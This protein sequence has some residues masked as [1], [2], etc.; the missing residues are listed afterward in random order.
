MRRF[1]IFILIS[2]LSIGT[3]IAQDAPVPLRVEYFG[4]MVN[5]PESCKLSAS[6][7]PK[8]EKLDKVHSNVNFSLDCGEENVKVIF[9][10]DL[11]ENER[12]S[13]MYRTLNNWTNSFEGTIGKEVNCTTKGQKLEHA[14][15]MNFEVEG[16]TMYNIFSFGLV[17][18]HYIMIST[19]L[20][21]EIKT[22]KDLP[23]F[24]RQ[25]IQIEN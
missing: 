24:V 22:F 15:L 19:T 9:Y 6:L 2:I 20:E 10:D 4:D 16:K 23:P 11:P 13:M 12:D 3:L 5:V 17:N 7:S 8:E 25:I 1:K 21:N 14:F 18:D